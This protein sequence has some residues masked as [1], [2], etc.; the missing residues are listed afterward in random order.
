[1]TVADYFTP[2]DQF[3]RNCQ[4]PNY[5]TDLDFGSGGV[6]L[7]PDNDLLTWPSLAVTGDKEGGLWFMNRANAG[8]YTA[9]NN[10]SKICPTMKNQYLCSEGTQVA[11]NVQT[12]WTGTDTSGP[13]IHTNPAYWESGPETSAT[14]YLYVAP[15]LTALTR[16]TLC[17]GTGATA[18]IGGCGVPIPGVDPTGTAVHFKY[19]AT[20]AISANGAAA[21]DAIV[22]AIWQDGAAEDAKTI[23]PP[24]TTGILY[25]F[26]AGSTG[27][28]MPQLY[29]SN[30][31][32]ADEM[33]PGTKFSV[34]TVAN[35]YVYV[36]GQS[37]NI[38]T[39]GQGTV[40][41]F[42]LGRTGC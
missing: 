13:V 12:Y 21:T 11:D 19:G 35:G 30:T 41:I 25:A 37:D 5:Y 40:Y 10:C 26:D 22:W 33:N 8:E 1:M 29:S 4:P 23:G 14:S 18:P 6:M 36:G 38:T 42:G 32:V 7:I 17:S 24:P 15:V 9:S 27:T 20:P 2:N 28:S 16:Y 31:C 39:V 3:Y 34:P